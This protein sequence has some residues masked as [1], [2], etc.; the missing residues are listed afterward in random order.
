[1][2]DS[3]TSLAE[4]FLKKWIWLYVFGYIIA[5]IG[6][7]VKILISGE[8][9]VSELGI[10]YGIISLI[11]LLSAFSD[12]GVWES[13]KYF[14]PQYIEK[15]QYAHI[16]SLLFYS[17]IIQIF[18][19]ILLM[20][21]F[22]FWADFLAENYFKNPLARESIQVFSLFFLW[23]NLFTIVS[24]FFLA[25]Q[26][27][28][29][30]KLIEFIRS[31]FLLI[32]ISSFLFLDISQLH[33]LASSWVIALYWGLVC[34]LLLFFKKYY[35]L[36]L[37]SEEIIWSR[38]LAKTFLKY[39]FIVFLSAQIWV[40]LSQI[41]MQM[42]IYLLSTTDAGYY[43][44]YMSLIMIPFL[45][46]G[47]IFSLLLPIFSEL[48]AQ[49]SEDKTV[50]LKSALTHIMI[51]AGM[52]FSFFLFRFS[53]QIAFTLFG[54]MFLISG[55]ILQFSCLFLIFNFLL[56]INF[57]ILG[58]EGKVSIKLKITCLALVINII[59]NLIFLHIFGV[60]GAALATWIGWCFIFILSE[61][62]LRR[63]YTTRY[64]FS[65]LFLNIVLLWALSA[66]SYFLVANMFINMS[67]I[68]TF[69]LL[70]AFGVIWLLFFGILNRKYF[71]VF[72]QEIK[73]LKN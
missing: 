14:I 19:G 68:E 54:E 42:I 56:Q 17:Y 59:L 9:S 50:K 53:E 27:T 16:K 46:I 66:S 32:S 35:N 69:L 51:L 22:L 44:V 61:I 31:I 47:P 34:A 58:G 64:N 43:S 63:S 23:I 3:H 55:Y 73:K 4:K 49:K 24:Q 60:A 21:L 33:L 18:S 67:R 45:I 15:K 48:S 25:V 57:N 36:Y 13:L 70:L 8:V 30:Y 5:P 52:F 29:Y 39:A 2:I 65:S 1:M 40:I 10:L 38:T 72:L 62:Y 26:N 41:D 11:T 71:Q 7:I 6:Y 37:A 12:L 20:L 28:L